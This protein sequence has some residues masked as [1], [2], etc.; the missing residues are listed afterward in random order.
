MRLGCTVRGS[1]DRVRSSPKG[2]GSSPSKS[3]CARNS[4]DP[5]KAHCYPLH[6]VRYRIGHADLVQALEAGRSGEGNMLQT[7]FGCITKETP[8]QIIAYQSRGSGERN[9]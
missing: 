9:K 1:Q 5:V 6:G 8:A 4:R 7:E 2:S 3:P